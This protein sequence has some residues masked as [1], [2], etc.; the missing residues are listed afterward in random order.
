MREADLKKLRSVNNAK[1][2][3]TIEGFDNSTGV[4]IG[5]RMAWKH[6]IGLGQDIT[7]ITPEGPDTPFGN[8]PRIRNYPIVAL[9]EIGM[10]DYD[11]NVI[12]MPLA[13]AQEFF[14]L[15]EAASGIEL[16]VDDPDDVNRYL[17]ALNI[18]SGPGY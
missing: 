12:Y 6:N 11:E 13:S 14:L 9:F 10:S 15:D 3:G 17:E 18:I 2:R 7:L 16:R 1:L 4:A 5:Y 8:A